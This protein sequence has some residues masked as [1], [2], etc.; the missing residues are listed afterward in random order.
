MPPRKRPNV[1]TPNVKAPVPTPIGTTAAPSSS[2]AP[3]T[4]PAPAANAL[5]FGAKSVSEM[6]TP[7]K[8]AYFLSKLTRFSLLGFALWQFWPKLTGSEPWWQA[9]EMA[10]P[11]AGFGRYEPVV[12]DLAKRRRIEDA[13]EWSWGAYEDNAFGADEYNPLSRTGHNISSAGG[14][15]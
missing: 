4:A 13:F 8:G 6:S 5:P 15:G 3:T 2:A 1:I 9:V 7:Q 11:S 10:A 12:A 14:V